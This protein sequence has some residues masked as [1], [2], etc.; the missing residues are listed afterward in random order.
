[1]PKTQSQERWKVRKI[2]RVPKG[3]EKP[4]GKCNMVFTCDWKEVPAD[5][6]NKNHETK[7]R[8]GIIGDF[9]LADRHLECQR[10][11]GAEELEKAAI[12]KPEKTKP[13]PAA[14]TT[15][16]FAS[17]DEKDEVMEVVG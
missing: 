16:I 7:T 2:S 15:P 11:T 4:Y 6:W 1:M 8:K 3:D 13:A 10:I 9:L 5:V 12:Q 17:T 14:A